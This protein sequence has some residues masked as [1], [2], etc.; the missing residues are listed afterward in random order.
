[1]AP[2]PL[3]DTMISSKETGNYQ[4]ITNPNGKQFR[5]QSSTTTF[6]KM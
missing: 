2:F 6:I 3:P 5:V 4:F 1:M